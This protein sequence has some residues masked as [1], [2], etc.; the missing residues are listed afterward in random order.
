MSTVW[1]I[2]VFSEPC[3]WRNGSL[4]YPHDLGVAPGTSRCKEL[5][6]TALTVHTILLFHKAHIS[7]GSLAVSTVEFF[8]VPRATHGDQERTPVKTKIICI[9]KVLSDTDYK[10][11]LLDTASMCNKLWKTMQEHIKRKPD[12]KWYFSILLLKHFAN[13]LKY[14]LIV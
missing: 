8:W 10:P 11:I 2:S 5:L 12:Q 7:Q 3:S 13:W 6:I 9:A 14:F 4:A 1:I